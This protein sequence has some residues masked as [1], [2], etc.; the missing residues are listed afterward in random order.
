MAWKCWVAWM[1]GFCISSTEACDHFQCSHDDNWTCIRWSAPERIQSL[2][3]LFRSE[4]S[5]FPFPSEHGLQTLLVCHSIL[6]LLQG[7]SGLY[8]I[9]WWAHLKGHNNTGW[10]LPL[11]ASSLLELLCL[12][13]TAIECPSV[14]GNKL[15]PLTL[16]AL[17]GIWP[18]NW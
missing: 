6:R 15:A 9:G 10:V 8:H 12:W 5:G 4:H 7:H 1:S 13:T 18:D 2:A 11:L 14:S 17:E 3:S 16:R